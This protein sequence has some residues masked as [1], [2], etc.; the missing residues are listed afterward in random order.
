MNEQYVEKRIREYSEV[1]I[2]YEE[3]AEQVLNVL[4]AIVKQEYPEMKI[5]SYSKRAKEVE[6]LRKKLQ[7][8]KI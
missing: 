2:R 8:D 6:S 4:K 3:F 7:K 5:A 1:R